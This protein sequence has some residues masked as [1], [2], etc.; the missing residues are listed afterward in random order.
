[1]KEIATKKKHLQ[2]GRFLLTVSCKIYFL[3][4]FEAEKNGLNLFG[5]TVG[6]G[7]CCAFSM[8]KVLDLCLRRRITSEGSL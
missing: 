8:P 5:P 7:L 1:M 6:I 4:K 3:V 2:F